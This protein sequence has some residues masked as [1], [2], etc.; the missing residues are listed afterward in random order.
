M[1]IISR[2]IADF[3]FFIG[4]QTQSL[5]GNLV[6]LNFSPWQVFLDIL[7]VAII[8]YSIFLLLR[9]SRAVHV[10]IGLI[11]ILMIYFLSKALQLVALGWLMDRFLT[12]TLVAIPVIFQQELRM[13]LE[14][15]GNTRFFVNQQSREIDHMIKDITDAAAKMA[16]A[17][18]GALIVIQHAVPLKEY[19][20]TGVKL[21]AKVSQELLV[22]IFSPGT[23]LHDGAVIIEHERIAA[24]ACLLPHS[25]SATQM[26]GTRHKAALGLSEN[27]DASV[28]VISEERGEISF[29]YHGKMA[30]NIDGDQLKHFLTENLKAL[31]PKK[32]LPFHKRFTK[33]Q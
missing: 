30:K 5:W 9:G 12:V 18:I 1:D 26:M 4:R 19:I 31:R 22:N 14:R 13:G 27:T 29:A 17:R 23:P 2:W 8:F 33:P 11:I 32:K 21:N 28:I 3:I 6:L 15:L 20:D 24:A 7:L 25:S 10:L 16:Q